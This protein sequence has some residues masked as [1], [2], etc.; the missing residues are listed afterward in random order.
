MTKNKF[1]IKEVSHIIDERF[2]DI[3]GNTFKFD[4]EKGLAE[5]LKNSMDAYLR[6]GTSLQDRHIVFRFTDRTVPTFECIDFVGMEEV[7]IEK[8][9]KRWGDPEA[10]KR[11]LVKRVYGGHGNG[12]KFYMRQ[13]FKTSYFITY[14]KGRLSVFGFSDKKKYGFADG[15]QNKAMEPL[16]A[17]KFAEIEG[18]QIPEKLKNKVLQKKMGFTVVKGSGPSGV[19]SKIRA[20]KIADKIKQHPQSRHILLDANISL[21]HNDKILYG[22]LRPDPIKPFG[23]FEEPRV[24][25][26][27]ETLSVEVGGDK[28]AVLLANKKYEPGRLILQTSEEAFARGSRLGDL[29]R[30]DMKGEIGVIGSYQIEELGVRTFPQASFIYGECRVP[31]L[32]DP[33]ND[34]VQ[35]DRAKLVDNNTT[36]ALLRWIAEE[37]DKLASEIASKEQEKREESNKKITSKYNEILNEWKNKHMRKIFSEIFGDAGAGGN[38][39]DDPRPKPMNLEVPPNGFDFRVSE[40]Q[41]PLNEPYP[42]TLKTLTPS[43]IPLGSVIFFSVN[44][45]LVELD[46]EK[47]T[48]KSEFIKRTEDGE[49]VAI[50]NVNATGQRLGEVAEIVAKA[51]KHEA[52]VRVTVVENLGSHGGKKPKH[53]QV[54]L[55]GH[56][57][58]PLGM[59]AGGSVILGERDPVVYQRPVDVREGIY[60]I[61]TSSPLAGGIYESFG[62]D[63]LQW[64]EFLFQRYIDIFV[65][66]LIYELHRKDP[67]NFTPERVD[68]EIGELVKKIHTTAKSDLRQ[69][70]FNEKYIPDEETHS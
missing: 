37:I 2:L 16:A 69:F 50:I 64:R 34:C 41:I 6:E 45:K 5:W 68:N 31:I 55:S 26:V 4:H 27:P 30:I 60:W 36:R 7:D 58:D 18:L 21:I 56:D 70:L 46:L 40:A 8:S 49:G 51:G 25:T 42:L 67:E 54:L 11:G 63:S 14:K 20:E 17:M 44:N 62:P 61:N 43:L 47:I 12:G 33:D 10:A 15:Y 9:F 19:K 57:P 22:L 13:M 65:K 48:V 32:E 35:N 23:G 38:G 29:N 39:K 59:T 1:N 3:I 66:E 24:V 52:R 53:P 28:V